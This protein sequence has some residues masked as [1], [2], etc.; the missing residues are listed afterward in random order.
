VFRPDWESVITPVIDYAAS[1]REIAAERIALFGYSMGAYLVARAAAFDSRVAAL[2]LD[3]GIYDFHRAFA[4]A[5]PP[6]VAE[7]I[8]AGRDEFA[9]PVLSMLTTA[10]S[11]VRFNLNNGLW[12]FG[13]D[14]YADLFRKSKDYTLDGHARKI[15]APTLIMDAE[16]DLFLKG[17]PAQ[18]EK[19]LTN[20]DTT[21]ATLTVAEG[22]GEH[23]HAGALARAHQVIFDWLDTTL[24]T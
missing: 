20:A 15:T 18:L 22:A 21:L 2:I 17:E 14:S 3:D 1:R 8:E 24:S 10:N 11:L 5:L 9:N 13:T 6:F 19:E 23:T 7:W 4:R 16:N 12:T